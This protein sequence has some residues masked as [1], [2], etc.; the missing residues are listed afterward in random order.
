MQ[1]YLM[2]TVEI[3]LQITQNTGNFPFSDLAAA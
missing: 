2:R 3:L 1:R